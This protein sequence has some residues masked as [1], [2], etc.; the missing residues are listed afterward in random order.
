M[1]QQKQQKKILLQEMTQSKKGTVYLYNV[2][3][4]QH[5]HNFSLYHV[6]NCKNTLVY[7]KVDIR[8]RGICHNNHKNGTFFHHNKLRHEI[9]VYKK[10][11]LEIHIRTNLL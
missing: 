5:L 1:H 9:E 8:D 6:E 3:K 10:K 11:N 4:E 7:S 2:P